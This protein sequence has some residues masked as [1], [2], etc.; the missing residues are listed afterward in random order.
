MNWRM[1]KLSKRELEVLRL[2]VKG[3]SNKQVAEY[4][5]IS[6]NTA[7]HH[8]ESVMRKMAVGGILAA[9]RIAIREKLVSMDDFLKSTI[10][11]NINHAPKK[12]DSL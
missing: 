6:V 1:K 11:E 7:E 9:T 10:G 4:L 5:E 8:R 12:E 3:L 2:M